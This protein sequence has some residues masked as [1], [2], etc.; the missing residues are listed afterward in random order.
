M[1]AAARAPRLCEQPFVAGDPCR[2]ESWLTA[3][4]CEQPATNVVTAEV[5]RSV[6]GPS[7]R[8]MEP[9]TVT[10][11]GCFQ[12]VRRLPLASSGV[13]VQRLALRPSPPVPGAR[14]RALTTGGPA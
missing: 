12:H 4:G 11:Y 13:T 10:T 5:Q 7:G 14:E 9:A 2:H 3:P 8:V 1:N 6:R